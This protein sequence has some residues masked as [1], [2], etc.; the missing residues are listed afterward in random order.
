MSL[1]RIVLV[2]PA[3]PGSKGDEGMVRGAIRFFESFPI[4]IVN[5][6]S[7]SSWLDKIRAV[8]A[9]DTRLSEVSGPMGNAAQQLR[10]GDL[11]FFIGA[12]VLDGTCGLD[13]AMER[14]DL[15]ADALLHGIKVYATCSF[16]SRVAS[17]ILR[18]LRLMPGMQFLLRDDDSL[19]NFCRQ[20]GLEANYFPDLSF[21]ADEG[22]SSIVSEAVEKIDLARKSHGPVIGVNFAEHSFRSF[23]DVHSDENR[24][25]YVSSILRELNDAY[26]SAFYVLFSNDV[27]RWVNH[28]SDDDYSDV[29]S[30]WLSKNLGTDRS[31]KIDPNGSY[32]DNIAILRS[33][34]FLTT[35]RMHLSLAAF[36]ASVV[37][38]VLM[39][40]GKGYT[41]VDKMRGAFF[42]FMGTTES[43]VSSIAGLGAH[44]LKLLASRDQ[45]VGRLQRLN[46]SMET[47][48][49]AFAD[50]LLNEFQGNPREKRESE[51]DLQAT[52]ISAMGLL[53]SSAEENAAERARSETLRVELS[54]ERANAEAQRQELA[55]ARA[56]AE[57]QTQELAAARANAEAQ[58]QELAAARASA[59]VLRL[60]SE[61]LRNE[62]GNRSADLDRTADLLREIQLHAQQMENSASWRLTKPVRVVAG[63]LP[64]PIRRTLSRLVRPTSSR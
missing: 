15:A 12:D 24:Q 33:V 11:L 32:G 41:S 26:P 4:V 45:I 46:S 42:K 22:K 62:L 17:P 54:A 25:E 49:E 47:S 64:G 51:V 57:A 23:F 30:D 60:E 38:F 8:S 16:R 36:R 6:E 37:P 29:A 27:R 13:P 56:H 20:T 52:F 14:L 1:R 48:N 3:A 61:A 50:S 2:P 7:D 43:V 40:Q 21:F 5:P 28:P 63:Q 31:F 18:R 55:A 59:E 19:A 53:A 35:G 58:G 9:Q 39:G 34:D 44:T 10:E